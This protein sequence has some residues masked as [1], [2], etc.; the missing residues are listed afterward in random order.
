MKTSILSVLFTIALV[1]FALVQNARAVV[2]APDGG[3]SGDNTAEGQNALLSLTTG[4]ANTAIGAQ[5]LYMNV[6][7]NDSRR[8][9]STPRVPERASQ[10]R[11][12]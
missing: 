3:Y 6:D 11:A 7:G 4:N 8:S 2:P 9:S 10:S 5:T 12:A 1:C